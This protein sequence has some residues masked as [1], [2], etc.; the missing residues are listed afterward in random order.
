MSIYKK[1][2]ILLIFLLIAFFTNYAV[3]FAKQPLHRIEIQSRVEVD[4]NEVYLGDLISKQSISPEW[5]KFF[6]TI[7]IGEAP[8][9]GSVKYVQIDLLKDFLEKLIKSEGLDPKDVTLTLPDEIVVTRKSVTIPKF[10]IEKIF[11]NHVLRNAPWNKSDISI[12]NIRYAGLPVVPA[13]QRRYEV[14]PRDHEPYLG[15]VTVTV[16]IYVNEKKARTL[17]VAGIVSLYKNVVHAKKI[18]NK[19]QI[20][21]PDAVEIRRAQITDN[22][23]EYPETIDLVVGKKALKEIFPGE[24]IKLSSLDNP[25]VVEKGDIVKIVLQKPGLIVTAKGMVK[26]NGHIGDTIKVMNLNSRK[27]IFCRVRNKETVQVID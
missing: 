10:E 22:P 17:R 16:N 8:E 6:N 24:P 27:I 25:I 7:Y 11:K 19:N 18:V 3:A 1:P 15:N 12:T 26:E 2:A 4:K 20:I 23:S 21:T 9:P 5:Q 14:I 13:G